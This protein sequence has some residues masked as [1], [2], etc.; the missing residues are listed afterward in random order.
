MDLQEIFLHFVQPSDFINQTYQYCLFTIKDPATGYI[1][2]TVSISI[3]LF[4]ERYSQR[5]HEHFGVETLS[6]FPLPPSSA[7]RD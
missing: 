6:A 3:F 2:C 7:D 5:Y 4:S 1:F